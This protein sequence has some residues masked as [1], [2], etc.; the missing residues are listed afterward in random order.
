MATASAHEFKPDGK[1]AMGVDFILNKPFSR[2][3][4]RQAMAL[5]LV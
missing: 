1:L 5:V 2:A 4:L 3:D